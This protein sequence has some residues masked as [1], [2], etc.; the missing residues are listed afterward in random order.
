ML[1]AKHLKLKVQGQKPKAK[2]YMLEAQTL[3]NKATNH[4]AKSPKLKA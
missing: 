1:K 2:V 4:K 3:K